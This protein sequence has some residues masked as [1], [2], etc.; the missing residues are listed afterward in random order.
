M[1]LRAVIVLLFISCKNETQK[2][3]FN[4]IKAE[5]A[6]IDESTKLRL[7][8]GKKWLANKETHI[9]IK[10]MD[11]IIKAFN[12]NDVKSLLICILSIL[13]FNIYF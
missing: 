7:D 13:K 4:T 6:T 3:N 12:A 5:E 9:G 8:N 11:S 2:N 1:L 10:N